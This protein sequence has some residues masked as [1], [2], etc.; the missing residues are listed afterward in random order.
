MSNELDIGLFAAKVGGEV[1]GGR[2]MGVVDGVKVYLTDY[3]AEDGQ[4]YMTEAGILLDSQTDNPAPKPS[5]R[6]KAKV[7]RCRSSCR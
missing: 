6:A 5:R 7:P 1:V 4:P 3:E 2:V